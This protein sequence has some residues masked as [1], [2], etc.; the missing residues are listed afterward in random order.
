M[1]FCCTLKLFVSPFILI[2]VSFLFSCKNLSRPTDS[3]Q[4]QATAGKEVGGGCDGC[5]IMFEGMA[6]NMDE[7]DTSAGW[8]EA[9]KK[10]LI[11]GTVFHRDGK[12]PAPG[13]IIYYWQ[14]NHEGYY[15]PAEGQDE[16]SRRHGHLRGW[17]KTGS[18]GSYSIYTIRPA[19]Y[20]HADI[21]AHIHTSVKEP[22]ISNPYYLDEFV[23]DDDT[24]L[25]RQK[26][27][28]LE[29]RGGS[30]ILKTNRRGDILV[31]EHDIILGM[32]IPAYPAE[33]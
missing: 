12:T 30:G 29:N 28:G 22:S 25:T 6:E 18:N 24:L 15:V 11:T 16:T 21:P 31:A 2:G 17:I 8:S 4:G 7:V 33:N 13:V 32:N 20:P 3:T 5:E 19:P 9:G 23:F 26:R 27:D 10:L 1:K 14:T